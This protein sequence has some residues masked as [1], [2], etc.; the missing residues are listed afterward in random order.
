MNDSMN[1]SYDIKR[2]VASDINDVLQLLDEHA[3]T[4]LIFADL[5]RYIILEG[6]DGFIVVDKSSSLV[7]VIAGHLCDTTS[8]I[9]ILCVS[10]SHRRQG[11]AKFL[12]NYLMQ[13]QVAS[14]LS[15]DVRVSNDDAQRV[16]ERWGFTRS[17]TKSLYYRNE[18]SYTM[19]KK[20]PS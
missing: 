20:I 17:G 19:M 9:D 3:N 6:Y 14:V 5:L 15:L 2:L 4:Q 16:Y 7:G 10:S 1:T 8:F 18:D 12:L 13:S 11:L